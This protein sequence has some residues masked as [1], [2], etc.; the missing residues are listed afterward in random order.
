VITAST[1]DYIPG[2]ALITK[3]T[4]ID[5]EKLERPEVTLTELA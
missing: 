4:V 5:R 3:G 1:K 2:K